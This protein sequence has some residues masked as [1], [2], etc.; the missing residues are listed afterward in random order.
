MICDWRLASGRGF[1]FRFVQLANFN[2]GGN[3]AELR[4]AQTAALALPETHMAVAIDIGDANDIHPRNKQEVARRLAAGPSPR[5]VS[6]RVEGDTVRLKFDQQLMANGPVKGFGVEAK[7]E[8]DTIV[9][10]K[11]DRIAYAWADNPE[12]NVTN[13]DGLPLVPFKI[14]P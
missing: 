3:W 2:A 1:E 8:G 10:P 5:F 11:A 6:M 13:R 9:L 12:C 4:D 7:I 14:E